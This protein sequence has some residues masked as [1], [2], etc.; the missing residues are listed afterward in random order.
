VQAVGVAVVHLRPVALVPQG[1]LHLSG[2]RLA[3]SHSPSVGNRAL[4]HFHPV[5]TDL[6]PRFIELL[7]TVG[8][9]SEHTTAS[10]PQGLP[11]AANGMLHEVHPSMRCG[12]ATDTCCRLLPLS[13]CAH[14]HPAKPGRKDALA[15]MP[16]TW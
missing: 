10:P 11:L 5:D 4:V 12:K 13:H 3:Y 15:L 2:L 1:N 7:H 14:V 9:L 6:C 8:L 16:E